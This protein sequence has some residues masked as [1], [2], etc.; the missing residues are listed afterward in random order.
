M[1][2]YS[3][4]W[5][6]VF[7]C[8]TTAVHSSPKVFDYNPNAPYDTIITHIGF[9]K[10]GNYYPE[11]AAEAFS[12]E[13]RSQQ[14]AIELAIQL[15][16]L[17]QEN[18][19]DIDLAQVPQDTHYIDPEAKYHKY[20][21][22]QVFPEIYL[23][24]VH[25][26]W[27]YSEE[28]VRS[29][30]I[31]T[32][33]KSYPLG[34][35]RLQELLPNSLKKEWW[36]LHLWQY[37]LLA[38]LILLVVGIYRMVVYVTARWL[39]TFSKRKNLSHVRRARRI[40]GLFVALLV[41]MTL[42]SIVQLPAVANQF[43]IQLLQGALILTMTALCYQWVRVLTP[44]ASHQ[45]KKKARQRNM[46]LRQLAL[47]FLQILVVLT[48]TLL[49]LKVF[50]F[51]ISH[52]L[53]GISIG[54]IGFALASQD[55]IKNFFGTLAIYVDQPFSVGDTIV[56]GNIK[57]KVEAIGLRA[58]RI[59][60][61]HQSV[62]YVPNAKLIDTHIDN[63]GLQHYQHFDVHI[64]IAHD[65]TPALIEAFT[66]GL[67]DIKTQY[68]DVREDDAYHTHLEGIHN[69]SLKMMLRIYFD[70]HDQDKELR[71]RHEVLRKI[72]KLAEGLGLQLAS[73]SL[74]P[75]LASRH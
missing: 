32:H 70:D 53:A 72:T 55:T 68:T 33:K 18:G 57:G 54:G 7:C 44:H 69:T 13:H 46:Q 73:L 56:T 71:Y 9:L 10:E 21:L 11:I 15:Q 12:Q 65:T 27:I 1:I 45:N 8:A 29:M 3:A 42:L 63:Y 37:I 36:G 20:Q 62:I 60:T 67:S 34:I 48:G 49:T 66:K 74:S 35:K 25:N 52:M 30:A 43:A 14:E 64:E 26:Q 61:H 51:D 41:L 6:L 22:T 40:I 4:T 28:T 2:R 38:A 47:P 39:Y 50:Q 75:N 19:V 31:L 24:K 16:Q 23:V 17:L 58:T 59:R 5:L